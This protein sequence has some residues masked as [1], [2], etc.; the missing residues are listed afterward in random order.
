M[1][2]FNTDEKKISIFELARMY[3]EPER[4]PNTTR[5]EINTKRFKFGYNATISSYIAT[6]YNSSSEK[7]DS[8]QGYFLEPKTDPELATTKNSDTAIQPGKYQII[9]R[10]SDKQ[11]YK[12][13][14]KDVNG[15]TGIAIHGGRHGNHTTG[16]L[17]PGTG[18]NVHKNEKGDSL[19][20]NDA[21]NKRDELFEF[22]ENYGNGGIKIDIGYPEEL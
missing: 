21:A 1:P 14:L 2:I 11:K 16:C 6:A 5:V 7:I 8:I 19:T 22:F 9:P 4:L 3:N 20:I 15:R 12:W 18:Y 10:W 13:Y 17:I